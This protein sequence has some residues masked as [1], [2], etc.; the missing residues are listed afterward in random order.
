MSEILTLIPVALGTGMILLLPA[1]I[2]LV[3]YFLK[4]W[5]LIESVELGFKTIACIICIMVL[6]FVAGMFT[7]HLIFT[8]ALNLFY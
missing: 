7:Y 6:P 3:F 1:W 4:R 5:N 8:I 2:Y